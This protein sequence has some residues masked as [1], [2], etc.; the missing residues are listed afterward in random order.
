MG[1]LDGEWYV[2][3]LVVFAFGL[4]Q[5]YLTPVKYIIPHIR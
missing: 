3:L 1:K 5:I 2:H 4:V